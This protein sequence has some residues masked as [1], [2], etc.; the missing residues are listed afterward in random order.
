M[1]W[2]YIY[3]IYIHI[4]KHRHERAYTYV[5]SLY[6]GSA[7]TGLLSSVWCSHWEDDWTRTADYVCQTAGHPW[8]VDFTGSGDWDHSTWPLQT[9][10]QTVWQVQVGIS[11]HSTCNYSNIVLMNIHVQENS[12]LCI[13]ICREPPNIHFWK[14][15]FTHRLQMYRNRLHLRLLNYS[16]KG[17]QQNPFC[18]YTHCVH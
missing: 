15:S 16:G 10:Q 6:T 11:M 18:H 5:Y 8:E 2:T 13:Y 9:C 14:Y 3:V 12:V 17:F 1:L 7:G 4:H